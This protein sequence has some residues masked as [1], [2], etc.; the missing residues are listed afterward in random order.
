MPRP[1]ATA[2]AKA[3][4]NATDANHGAAETSPPDRTLDALNF[5][6]ADVRDG[7][8]PYLAIYLVA[9]RGRAYGW[10]EAM[11]G[12][13]LTLAGIVGLPSQ[14]PVGGLID[15]SR[16]KPRI[17]MIAALLVT[18][19]SIAPPIVTGCSAVAVTRSIAAIAGLGLL[20]YALAMPETKARSR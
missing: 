6:F 2:P 11:V 7:L 9:V 18:L 3:G 19:C 4:A 20:P 16:H 5:F 15:R 8:G 14:T 13:V 17:V 1:I 10:N 12:A